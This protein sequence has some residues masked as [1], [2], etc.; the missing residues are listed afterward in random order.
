M[1][2]TD[3]GGGTFFERGHAISQRKCRLSVVSYVSACL[4]LLAAASCRKDRI[5]PVPPPPRSSSA[6]ESAA[7][8]PSKKETYK[9]EIYGD[10]ELFKEPR[11]QFLWAPPGEEHDSI[12]SMKLDG[13]D[14]RRAAGPEVLYAADA[15]AVS[16]LYVPARSPNGRYVACGAVDA[17]GDAIR[18]LVDLKTKKTR[19]MIVGGAWTNFTWSPDSKSVIFYADLKLRQFDVEDGVLS[20]PPMIYSRGLYLVDRGTRF[21]AVRE[22]AIEHY[23]RQGKKLRQIPLPFAPNANSPHVASTDGRTFLFRDGTQSVIL[24]ADASVRELVRD[25][26]YRSW[27]AFS[28]DSRILYYVKGLTAERPLVALE[29]SSGS[30][31]QLGSLGNMRVPGLSLFSLRSEP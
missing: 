17:N 8:Q 28:P 7:E 24:R 12:W 13:S 31:R 22:R 11:L 6:I 14:V 30:E 10:T 18:L 9:D 25:D 21:V 27:A 2:Q 15:K 3:S 20:K 19:T 5:A 29:V 23:D 4:V 16:E 26:V 1:S